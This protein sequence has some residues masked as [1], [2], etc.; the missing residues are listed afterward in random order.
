MSG[1][2]PSTKRSSERAPKNASPARPSPRRPLADKLGREH[3]SGGQVT[4]TDLSGQDDDP[5][6]RFASPR[7]IAGKQT[8]PL[9]TTVVQTAQPAGKKDQATRESRHP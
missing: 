6:S 1:R 7:R 5:E 4:L 8:S 9:T 2:Q 3:P